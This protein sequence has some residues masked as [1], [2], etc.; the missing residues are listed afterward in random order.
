MQAALVAG[1]LKAVGS[2]A[3]G[4]AAHSAG[5]YNARQLDEQRRQALAA[6]AENETQSR[7]DFSRFQGRQLAN[8]AASGVQVG[9]GSALDIMTDSAI[10]AERDALN[11]RY[12]G[13][14]EG[15]R[16]KAEA[17]MQRRQAKAARIGGYV[18]AASQLLG[19]YADY[20]QAK[21]IRA[22]EVG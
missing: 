20:R 8:I 12:Q 9:T 11:I 3:S 16:L 19:S 15:S 17:S 6:T 10:A 18:G 7:R 2:I 21:K 13:A 22:G 1:G 14:L 5:I 4:E